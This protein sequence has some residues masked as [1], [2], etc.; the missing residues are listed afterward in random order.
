VRIGL[1]CPY[2]LSVDGGVQNQ[3][4]GLAAW[5]R[6]AG[7]DVGVLAPGDLR[8]SSLIHDLEPGAVTSAGPAT[9]IRFNG[10]VAPIGLRPG[11]R[12]R[13]VR[14]MER[15]RPDVLHV[16]EPLVPWLGVTAMGQRDV[17]V[18]GT[19]HASGADPRL[20]GLLAR[21]ARSR[22]S[23][24]AAATAVSSTAAAWVRDV[25]GVATRIVP[26][27][28]NT[29]DFA[30]PAAQSAPRTG[31][32]RLT[33]LGR[34]DEPRKG[35][36]I[37][38]A[39]LPEL[40]RRHPDLVVS[41]AGRGVV[42]G[43]AAGTARTVGIGAGV[44][45]LGEISDQQRNDLLA[46]S[47]VFV[48]PNTGRESFGLVLVEAL[49]AGARV[50]ASDLPAFRDV[51]TGPQGTVGVLFPVGDAAALA[52]AV[53]G[54]LDRASSHQSPSV[55]AGRRRAADFDWDVVGPAYLELLSASAASAGAARRRY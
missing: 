51:L 15:F 30:G 28:V 35:L 11:A 19:F 24:L 29:R 4:L 47:D 25:M 14:W 34:L 18:V 22:L 44:E 9:R 1:V 16:H 6:S 48:A 52:D 54:C 20:V 26:N 53:D 46:R 43:R 21:M 39:A 3:V 2:S 7:H 42:G 32:P 38:L 27:A 12:R 10:S 49:A 55:A 45:V 41:L 40:L 36:P 5:L 8:P 17:P 31:P 50:V 37:L 33:F 13:T 23:G